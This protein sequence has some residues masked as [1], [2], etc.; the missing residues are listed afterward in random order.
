MWV[1]IMKYLVEPLMVTMGW[2]PGK[3]ALIIVVA[4]VV[5]FCINVYHFCFMS[6]GGE[7]YEILSR[8]RQYKNNS[9]CR[10][11]GIICT[12]NA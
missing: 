1:L 2:C 9:F 11:Q 4:V 5:I 12:K 3:G 10:Q 6:K 7:S 8:A